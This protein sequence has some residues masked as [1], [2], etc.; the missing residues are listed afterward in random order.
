MIMQNVFKWMTVLLAAGVLQSGF[1]ADRSVAETVS[2]DVTKRLTPPVVE[3]LSTD[4]PIHEM[5]AGF[6][7][8]PSS[9]KAKV[10]WHWM[11][12][13]VTREGITADLE[14]MKHAGVGGAIIF[15]VDC[16]IQPG[17][18]ISPGDLWLENMSFAAQEAKRLELSLGL[19]QSPGWSGSAGPWITPEYSMQVLTWSETAVKGGHPVHVHSII[20]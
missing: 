7:K 3:P 13:N 17:P 9:A 11:N 14:A 19:H 1:G 20:T 16:G 6:V 15:E 4:L 2:G 5:R 8:P 10:W 18:M 12:G